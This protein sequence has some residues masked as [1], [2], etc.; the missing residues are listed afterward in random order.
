MN[1]IQSYTRFWTRGDFEIGRAIANLG[2]RI[3]G[4]TVIRRTRAES[5]EAYSKDCSRPEAAARVFGAMPGS[6]HPPEAA[7]D[8]G[9]RR[10]KPE[11]P[12]SRTVK[13]SLGLDGEVTQ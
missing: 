11:L 4:C 12:E 2:A 1:F 9:T 7:A 3:I 6:R 8:P 13:V 10:A 5:T